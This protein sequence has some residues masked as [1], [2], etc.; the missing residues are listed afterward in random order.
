MATCDVCV[1]HRSRR[2]IYAGAAP[3]V[4]AAPDLQAGSPPSECRLRPGL[5]L[6]SSSKQLSRR[7]RDL[8]RLSPRI[9][10]GL[11][12]KCSSDHRGK[13]Q[14][15]G[16][17]TGPSFKT[18]P[19]ANWERPETWPRTF[20]DL[21]QRPFSSFVPARGI[22]RVLLSAVFVRAFAEESRHDD[23][24]DCVA[25][26]G[27]GREPGRVRQRDHAVR[28]TAEQGGGRLAAHRAQLYALVSAPVP[29]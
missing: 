26:L 27:G 29:L 19:G 21:S 14:V 28:A 4:G 24:R 3:G 6:A 18:P 12:R 10:Q 11:E 2:K 9:N 8:C 23:H 20:H 1:R 5:T 22:N 17:V 16:P 15:L 25:G 13:S 7:C